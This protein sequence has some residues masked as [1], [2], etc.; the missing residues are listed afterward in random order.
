MDRYKDV[1]SKYKDMIDSFDCDFDLAKDTDSAYK[2]GHLQSLIDEKNE[3]LMK[4][5]DL[6]A[7]LSFGLRHNQIKIVEVQKNGR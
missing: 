5:I 2:I 1:T 4:D 3:V 7:E 6:L